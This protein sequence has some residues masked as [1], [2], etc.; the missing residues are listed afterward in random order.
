MFLII[1]SMLKENEALA[2]LKQE[3]GEFN[4]PQK[5][6]VENHMPRDVVGASV[7]LFL[8][9]NLKASGITKQEVEFPTFGH[10]MQFV[11]DIELV[12]KAN[13]FEKAISLSIAEKEVD[14]VEDAHTAEV[15]DTHTV[16]A[17]R[18]ETG[19]SKKSRKRRDKHQQN[20]DVKPDEENNKE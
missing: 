10:L 20:E 3:C 16:E 15:E 2:I 12:A 19:E 4:F 1:G 14:T 7:S 13:D 9:S 8:D 11:T 6:T 5:I 18:N 17:E